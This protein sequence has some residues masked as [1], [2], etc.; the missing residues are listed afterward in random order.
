VKLTY[1]RWSMMIIETNG[2]TLITDP[3]FGMFGVHQAPR[4]YTFE[5][6]QR[7]DLVFI[8]H[9][10][11]DHFEPGVLRRL[12]AGTPVLMAT[13]KLPRAAGLGLA[14]LHGVHEWEPVQFHGLRLTVVPAAHSGGEVGLVIAGDKTVYFAGDTSLDRNLFRIIAQ[15]WRLDA[16]LLP[17]GDLRMLALPFRHMGPKTGAQAL[18]LLGEPRI[19]VPTHY[20]GM[21]LGPLMA[22]RGTPRKL[23]QAIHAAELGTVVGTTRPLEMVEI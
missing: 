9:T 21:T 3:V 23:S 18:R 20:S 16:V 8:S 11:I 17:I 7:P 13:D 12:P 5:Q 6:M 19:V 2:L 15:R 1:I 4:T 14:G 22:F 10:H